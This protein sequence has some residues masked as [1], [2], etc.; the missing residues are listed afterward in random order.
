VLLLA[1]G[2]KQGDFSGCTTP[3]GLDGRDPFDL[4][5]LGNMIPLNVFHDVYIIFNGEECL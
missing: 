5:Q 4:H 1:V 3:T 2:R